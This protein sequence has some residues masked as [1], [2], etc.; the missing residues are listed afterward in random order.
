MISS[1]NMTRGSYDSTEDNT[2]DLSSVKSYNLKSEP[3]SGAGVGVLDGFLYCKIFI[4]QPTN[5]GIRQ[6]PLP[7]WQNNGNISKNVT[8]SIWVKLSQIECV[9]F[10][11][12]FY[13]FV[14][15]ITN[16]S[17]WMSKIHFHHTGV[18]CSSVIL[19]QPDSEVYCTSV[20][21]HGTPRGEVVM[22]E[23]TNLA[24]LNNTWFLPAYQ[25]IQLA[26]V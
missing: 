10:L 14:E 19:P 2:Q 15:Y 16:S 17:E 22:V 23:H 3:K 26:K 4:H 18:I 24:K 21:S 6:I 13:R 25:P 5:S 8:H 9:T 7:P 20:P 12:I 11:N 1:Q